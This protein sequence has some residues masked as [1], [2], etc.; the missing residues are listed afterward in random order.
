MDSKQN[1]VSPM[2][3]VLAAVFVTCLIVANVVA[4]KLLQIG[5]LVLAGGLLCFPIVYIIGDVVPE[6][7]GLPTARKI[8]WLGFACNLLAVAFF[9]LTLRLPYA[10]FWENQAAFETVLSVTPRLLLASFVAYLCGTNVNAWVLV[11]IK[12]ATGPKY[13]WVRTITSTLFGE[14]IDSLVFTLIAFWGVVPVFAI[15]NMVIGAALAK[16]LYEAIVTPV[17]YWVINSIKRYE[18]KAGREIANEPAP[19]AALAGA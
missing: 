4:S 7:Y 5:P 9:V 8:I 10:P 17:T 15:P 12:Q 2:L 16:T 19:V 6:V 1:G 18:R 14:G 11:R 3:V 13:L